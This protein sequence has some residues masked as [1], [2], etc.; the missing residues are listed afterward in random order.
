MTHEAKA[1]PAL[2]VAFNSHDG[3]RDRFVD[4]HII[5]HE[6]KARPALQVAFNS[7]KGQRDRSVDPRMIVHADNHASK[8]FHEQKDLTADAVPFQGMY[9]LF[10]SPTDMYICRDDMSAWISRCGLR[11]LSGITHAS[12]CRWGGLGGKAKTEAVRC[13]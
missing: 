1:R 9:A 7:H 11:T 6:A 10:A 5:M 4:L 3:Q 2:Q 8:N 13:Q 12:S